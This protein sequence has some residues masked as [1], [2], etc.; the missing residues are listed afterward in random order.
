MVLNPYFLRTAAYITN[1][2]WTLSACARKLCQKSS[3]TGVDY[4]GIPHIAWVSGDAQLWFS[5]SLAYSLDGGFDVDPILHSLL[6]RNDFVLTSRDPELLQHLSKSFHIGSNTI[7]SPY[8]SLYPSAS[9]LKGGQRMCGRR[10]KPFEAVRVFVRW[11][12]AIKSDNNDMRLGGST[13]NSGKI[14]RRSRHSW[15]GKL[16]SYST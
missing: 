5:Q 1:S 10:S 3:P 8:L 4:N 14:S 2:A 7:L 16:C 13:G 12:R 15:L 11:R 9:V 6:A